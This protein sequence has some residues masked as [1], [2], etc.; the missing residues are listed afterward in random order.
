MTNR[1]GTS[2]FSLLIFSIILLGIFIL[3]LVN[4]V[5]AFFNKNTPQS[6]MENAWVQAEQIGR[7]QFETTVLQTI[8]PALTI[9]NVGMSSRTEQTRIV[10][11]LDRPAEQM[12]MQ[13][14]VA[15]Q[16]E[17]G[18]K[19]EDGVSYGRINENDEWRELEA[20]TDF[21]APGGDPMGFLEAAENVTIISADSAPETAVNVQSPSSLI[22]ASFMEDVTRYQF[23]LSGPQYASYMRDQLQQQLR[24]EGR[25]PQGITLALA[26]EY[27][28]MQGSGELWVSANG[29]PVRQILTL[30]FPAQAGANEWVEAQIT[31]D[32][33]NWDSRT[34]EAAAF[35]WQ[36]PTASAAAYL[37]RIDLS[38]DI[39]ETTIINFSLLFIAFGF[40]ALIITQAKS[41][42][43]RAVINITIIITML[44]AP[45]LQ[46]EEMAAFYEHVQNQANHDSPAEETNTFEEQFDPHANPLLAGNRSTEQ[47]DFLTT[48][49]REQ[50]DLRQASPAPLDINCNITTTSDCDGDGLIDQVEIFEL[51]TRIDRV[52]TD[53]DGISD[54]LEVTGFDVGGRTWYT[55]PRNP[56]TN[57]DGTIDGDECLERRNVITDTINLSVPGTACSDADNDNIPEIFDFDNDGDGVPDRFDIAPNNWYTVTNKQFDFQ[58]NGT[59][60][61]TPLYVD[62]LLRPVDDQHLWWT[63]NYLDWPDEDRSG[64]IMRVTTQTLSTKGDMQLVPLLEVTLPYTD[65]NR[66]RGLPILSSANYNNITATTPITTWVDSS[67]L[68][69]YGISV[70]Q[71]GGDNLVMYVPLNVVEDDVGG[72][73][74]S[75]TARL[76]YQV[77]SNAV[78]WGAAHNMRLLWTVQAVSD[79]CT[80]PDGQD[81]ETY[82]QSEA[83]WTSSKTVIQTYPEDFIVAGIMVEEDLGSETLMIGQNDGASG[84]S[85]YESQLWYLADVLQ[86]S[87]M[88]AQNIAPDTRMTLADISTQAVSWGIPGADL[89]FV[90]TTNI[91][92]ETEFLKSISLDTAVSFLDTT[93]YATDPVSGT[94]ANILYL[95]ESTK[96]QVSL[97]DVSLTNNGTQVISHTTYA[98]N[99]I[100]FDLN[101][102]STA[103]TAAMRFRPYQF[104]TGGWTTA[105]FRPTI[106][107][108]GKDMQTVFDNSLLSSISDQQLTDWSAAR[109]GAVILAQSYYI[110]LFTGITNVVD[111]TDLDF[112]VDSVGTYTRP[113]EP[114]G[115][116]VAGIASDIQGHYKNLSLENLNIPT[117]ST[118][119][120]AVG[121]AV[122]QTLAGAYTAVL[123]AFGDA[124]TKGT[125][126]ATSLALVELNSY[127]ISLNPVDD[128]QITSS[129]VYYSRYSSVNR[130]QSSGFGLEADGTSTFGLINGD[131]AVS[132]LLTYRIGNTIKNIVHYTGK[133]KTLADAQKQLT[134]W[135]GAPAGS[136]TQ[137]QIATYKGVLDA[138]KASKVKWG[139]IGIAQTVGMIMYSSIRV[140]T[141]GTTDPD[142]AEFSFFLA[143]QVAT[144]IVA[145]T[146]F[147]ITVAFAASGIASLVFSILYLVDAIIAA[148]CAVINIAKPGTIQL[149]SNVDQWVC[150]GITGAI[151]R[152]LAYIINDYTP[153][154]DLDHENRL[155]TSF[156][157]PVINAAADVTGPV[158]GNQLTLSAT[159]TTTLHMDS[160]NW[161]GHL[162]AW[163][164]TDDRLDDAAFAY[165]IQKDQSG[166]EGSLNYGANS[167]TAVPGRSNFPLLSGDA[168]FYN[169]FPVQQ[170]YTYTTAGINKGVPLYFSEALLT[171]TQNCW[172]IPNP[173]LIPPVVPTCWI[174]KYDTTSHTP[175]NGSFIYDVLPATLDG[176]NTLIQVKDDSYRQAWDSNF[177]TLMDGDGDGLISKAFNGIDPDDSSIDTDGD[178][179]TDRFEMNND[180]FDERQ[181]DG[182]VMA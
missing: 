161:M 26:Q 35:D 15:N 72:T 62:M 148:V 4:P 46:V 133:I 61:N 158:V 83:N 107:G 106:E 153:L 111:H 144:L 10:G 180:G 179:L 96:R 131:I 104:N 38:A 170:V 134:H 18:V 120:Q 128:K 119:Q 129:A 162:Y 87:Y 17:I 64:Q 79:S 150:N 113:T 34:L 85:N 114:V 124:F 57:Q 181:A 12:N 74:L 47:A 168:R 141:D 136:N 7:Y 52:D 125:S 142:S 9:E 123:E 130:F 92:N 109:T 3:F 175:L 146:K 40:V 100:T 165:R 81:R 68:D 80:P 172:L 1:I 24:E 177:P 176:F 174:Q 53:R 149:G 132:A 50:L 13:L 58:L 112:S 166:F 30:T 154:V 59:T 43:F 103:T 173:I 63:N 90:H 89:D 93:L 2:R 49:H 60:T 110:A 145:V 70:A 115:T 118:T 48:N 65:S 98:N 33:S 44:V 76:H 73:P 77:D 152:A 82:C 178:G 67:A 28:D 36:N 164:L 135:L 45:L 37:G 99:T 151:T 75:W 8:H 56:D 14:I 156:A 25:L 11:E 6:Q 21:F 127:N 167:W 97:G 55:D 117:A 101:S 51:G 137:K 84:N 20:G 143:M 29:L 23:D 140:A 138:N 32:F 121:T 147:A 122:W 78:D 71:G 69:P 16:P 171:P 22:P 19:V 155:K 95:S 31:T 94:V 54:N 108:V 169:E 88:Q 39:V 41:P 139:W 86:E 5:T 116:I 42:K 27:V 160:P 182:I 126:S 102:L 163:Q 159:V 105:Q 91:T 66:T 157:S